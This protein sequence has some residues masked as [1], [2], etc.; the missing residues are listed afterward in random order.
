M[1]LALGQIISQMQ[2]STLRLRMPADTLSSQTQAS[3]AGSQ[4]QL[5]NVEHASHAAFQMGEEVTSILQDMCQTRA[6][7]EDALQTAAASRLVVAQAVAND[8][9]A[10][11]Q[12]LAVAKSMHALD[13][14]VGNIEK[15]I[16][17]IREI[18]DQTNLLALNAAI[19][20]APAGEQRRG[21]A[22]VAEQVHSLAAKTLKATRQIE[23]TL[24]A[25]L[26]ATA[27]AT[28][29]VAISTAESR[30]AHVC[31]G[32]VDSTPSNIATSCTN[33]HQEIE[34]VTVLAARQTDTAAE[35]SVTQRRWMQSLITASE[36]VNALS[37]E[38]ASLVKLA[39]DLAA[40]TAKFMT[41]T[42][43]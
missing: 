20:A 16:S 25:V 23:T 37:L 14:S 8:E 17:V 22:I 19:E 12:S 3:V 43:A 21:F 31:M 28:R 9:R 7:S 6:A 2:R 34:K 18:A 10:Q 5:R 39:N 1:S 35:I 26:E 11:N 4:K 38:A 15:V 36:S 32:E 30:E 33:E 41:T 29:S 42:A 40:T 27:T 24:N 13:E